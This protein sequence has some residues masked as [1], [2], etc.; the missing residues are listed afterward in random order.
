MDCRKRLARIAA[1][2]MILIIPNARNVNIHI[3]E[4]CIAHPSHGEMGNFLMP[5]T[6]KHKKANFPLLYLCICDKMYFIIICLKLRVPKGE[7]I[8][9]IS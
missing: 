3:N 5:I 4:M 9:E 6:Q 7:F 1:Q 2:F 8:C